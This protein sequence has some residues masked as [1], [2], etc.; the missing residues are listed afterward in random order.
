MATNTDSFQRGLEKQMQKKSERHAQVQ[1]Y[2]IIITDETVFFV[3]W[4]TRIFSRTD[5]I[6]ELIK[7]ENPS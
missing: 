1:G 4:F 5:S 7:V 6:S 3:I 2:L